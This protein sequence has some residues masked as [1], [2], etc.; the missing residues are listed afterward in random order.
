MAKPQLI[1]LSLLAL[2]GLV[3][4]VLFVAANLSVT[5]LVDFEAQGFE[6]ENTADARVYA[7][8]LRLRSVELPELGIFNLSW[9]WCPNT[10]LL[11]WCTELL[12]QALEGNG[13]I[14]LKFT[15]EL[16]LTDV[17][18]DLES[19]ASI[20]LASMLYDAKVRGDIDSALISDVNCPLRGAKDIAAEFR[21]L[22]MHML[23]QSMD[24]VEIAVSQSSENYLINLAGTQLEGELKVDSNLDYLGVGE[25]EPPSALAGMMGSLARP[26]GNGRYAWEIQGQVPC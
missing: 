24:E 20:G 14:G 3:C 22:E 26:L 18:I 12:G 9:H 11:T 2:I 13:K 16:K 25:I 10:T 1:K 6:V 19:L 4:M 5:R 23:G 15:G 7:G 17:S 8:S 21:L